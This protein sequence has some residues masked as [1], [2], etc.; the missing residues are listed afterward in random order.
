M[1]VI[2]QEYSKSNSIRPLKSLEKE[3]FLTKMY[4]IKWK[5]N[6]AMNRDFRST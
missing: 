3:Y 1:F 5:K 6:S 2:L 4:S